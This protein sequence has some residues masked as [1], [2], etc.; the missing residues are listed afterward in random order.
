MSKKFY[1]KYCEEFFQLGEYAPKTCPH[2]FKNTGIMG[3]Y[4]V[5]DYWY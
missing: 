2:C 1:C 4:N 3:P 5:S